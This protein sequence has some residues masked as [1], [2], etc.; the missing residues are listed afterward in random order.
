MILLGLSMLGGLR[1]VDRYQEVGEPRAR[2]V[3]SALTGDRLPDEA[4]VAM[5]VPR[6][7]AVD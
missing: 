6:R 5:R 1:D 4:E 3:A 7:E 2:R